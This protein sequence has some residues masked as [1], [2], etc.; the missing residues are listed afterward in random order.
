[1]I[2]PKHRLAPKA[3]PEEKLRTEIS[4]ETGYGFEVS[5]VDSHSETKTLPVAETLLVEVST[6][7]NDDLDDTSLSGDSAFSVTETPLAAVDHN[8]KA[9]PSPRDS[10]RSWNLITFLLFLQICMFWMATALVS[11]DA[12]KNF[13]PPSSEPRVESP[14]YSLIVGATS[15]EE[16]PESVYSMMLSPFM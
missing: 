8:Q 4:E 9:V 16:R 2:F 1:M 7:S 14:F 5:L 15:G 6:N 13:A 3:T 12:I 11:A 10:R